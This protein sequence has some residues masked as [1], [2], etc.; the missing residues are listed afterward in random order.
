VS[1]DNMFVSYCVSRCLWWNVFFDTFYSECLRNSCFVCESGRF[2]VSV[3][4]YL[5]L[6]RR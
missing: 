4:R 5:K 6:E 2:R 1:L 3:A